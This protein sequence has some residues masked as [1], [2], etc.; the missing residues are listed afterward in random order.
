MA[1]QRTY[2][3]GLVRD[4]DLLD[5]LADPEAAAGGLGVSAIA[6][7]AGRD[8]AQVSRAL[9]TMAHAGLVER[10]DASK[11]YRPGWKLFALAAR[12][13]HAQLTALAIPYMRDIVAATHET[14]HLCC[15]RGG[16]VLTLHSELGVNAYRGLGWEGQL[17]APYWTSAGRVLMSELD[18]AA[19][20][21]WWQHGTGPSGTEPSGAAA[22]AFA[23]S[24][25]EAPRRPAVP[26]FDGFA[27]TLEEVRRAGYAIID[28]EFESGLV[29]VS[30]PIRDFRGA[31][32]A[33]FNIAGPKAR[34][35]PNLHAA[36]AYAVGVANKFS[37]LLGGHCE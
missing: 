23:F 15:L 14:T 33:V 35:G 13:L 27:S 17:A 1:N 37:A 21:Y 12:S 26:T 10:N 34:L 7:L 11:T 25:S 16:Q 29:G 5:V 31:I 6:A 24:P 32:T 2:A 19:L 36:A 18:D 9:S 30:A 3:S 20:R 22:A 4:I 8:K 28:E